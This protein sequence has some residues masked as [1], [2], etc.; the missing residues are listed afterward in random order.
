MDDAKLKRINGSWCIPAKESCPF[1]KECSYVDDCMRE[2]AINKPFSCAEA[3]SLDGT[4]L[5]I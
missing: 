5:R 2:K 4:W 1:S 3:R